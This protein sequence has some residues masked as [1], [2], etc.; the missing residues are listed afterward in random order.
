[1]VSANY[2]LTETLIIPD[3]TKTECLTLFLKKTQNTPSNG[4]Q[5]DIALGN[6][7]LCAQPRDQRVIC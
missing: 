4:A 3:V 6:R 2:T 7:A 1:M 5:F